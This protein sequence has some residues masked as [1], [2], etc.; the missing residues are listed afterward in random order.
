MD[1]NT[2]LI[3]YIIAKL[4][5]FEGILLLTC[6]MTSDVVERKNGTV[7]EVATSMLRGK[8]L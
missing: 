8:Y 1:R 5:I 2:N 6:S 4:M 7:M 3:T